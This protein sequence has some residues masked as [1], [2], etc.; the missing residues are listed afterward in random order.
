MRVDL[1]NEGHLLA[2]LHLASGGLHITVNVDDGIERAYAL[3]SGAEEP[4]GEAAASRDLLA[5]WRSCFPRDA[6]AL[7][8]LSAPE[9]FDAAALGARPLLVKLHGTLGRSRDGV[10]LPLGPL[11]PDADVTDLGLARTAAIEALAAEAFVVVTGYSGS[12]LASYAAIVERLEPGRFAWVAPEVRPDV[13]SRLRTIDPRQPVAARPEDVLRRHLAVTLPW[14]SSRRR[15]PGFPKRF[16]AWS[17]TLAPE[18]AAEA[19]AWALGDAGRHAEA[20]PLLERLHVATGERRTALRLADAIVA[21][22]EAGDAAA[23][24]CIFRRTTRGAQSEVRA[25]SLVR[26]AECRADAGGGAIASAALAS[27]GRRRR[28]PGGDVLGAS[29]VAGI[30]LDLLERHVTRTVTSRARLLA[31]RALTAAASRHA[32][33]A[34]EPSAQAPAGRQRALLQRQAVELV[35]I[36]VL[37]AGRPA[38]AGTIRTL[39]LLSEAFAHLEDRTGHADTLATQALVLLSRGETARARHALRAAS[40]LQSPPSGVRRAVR[41]LLDRA[42]SPPSDEAW[43]AATSSSAPGPGRGKRVNG[44]RRRAPHGLSSDRPA[45]VSLRE[46]ANPRRTAASGQIRE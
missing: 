38:P 8:T 14:A 27:A 11:L 40:R 6:P 3:L 41:E 42:G 12:D 1:P 26:W 36:A 25:Y 13:R 32:V 29:A 24:A 19:F 7:R 16:A 28:R 46:E 5:S 21:R 35:A 10:V 18:V 39:R 15:R 34:L 22:G 30:V 4:S 45:H 33:G 23:A 31:L 44:A 37:L 20:V 43:R 2:A 9:A 17:A